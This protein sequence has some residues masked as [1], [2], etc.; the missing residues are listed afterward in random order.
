MN[1]QQAPELR[2]M[3]LPTQLPGQLPGPPA[4]PPVY[5]SA[6]SQSLRS[7]KLQVVPEPIIFIPEGLPPQTQLGLFWETRV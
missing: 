3:A 5:C 7:R 2:N 4:L 6:C 1:S